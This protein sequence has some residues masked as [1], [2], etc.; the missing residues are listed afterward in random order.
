MQQ[1]GLA[2]PLPDDE[3]LLP[4][5]AQR[6]QLNFAFDTA[7]YDFRGLVLEMFQAR[8]PEGGLAIAGG[9]G[10][11]GNGAMPTPEGKPGAGRADSDAVGALL[12]NLHRTVVAERKRA[13]QATAKGGRHGGGA[14]FLAHYATVV[15]SGNSPAT[16]ALRRRFHATLL[17]FARTVVAPLLGC[18]DRPGDVAFQRSPTLRVSF[19]ATEPMGHAHT[20]AEYH[21]QAGELN[22]WL[23][24][25][26]VWGTNTL[27]VDGTGAEGG[28]NG[29]IDSRPLQLGW[30]RGVRF[31]GN[32]IRH[33]CVANES[34]FTRVSLDFRAIDVRR[35]DHTF[36]DTR[37]K[38]TPFR[39][40][41][42]YR[43]GS[44][45]DGR[46]EDVAQLKE[47]EGLEDRRAESRCRGSSSQHEK[48]ADALQDST[49][50]AGGTAAAHPVVHGGGESPVAGSSDAEGAAAATTSRAGW[51]DAA[52]A[53][54]GVGPAEKHP[55][56][57]ECGLH[58]MAG[59]SMFEM[60]AKRKAYREAQAN[61]AAKGTKRPL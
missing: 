21:H 23:P 53:L 12:S 58:K 37:G 27:W 10:S 55:P 16:E 7:A 28:D 29:D 56:F 14:A 34:G 44:D 6:E 20:D 22:F 26:A 49:A 4:T 38:P 3:A 33:H 60:A 43:L 17:A 51:A 41:Q 30:G 9:A 31:W 13:G 61:I 50:A 24:L 54:L 15:R 39:L 11:D 19:P 52:E 46:G 2:S 47:R 42:Y 18:A 8:I 5:P 40:G 1:P 45:S 48:K 32:R 25:T 35:F 57:C 36:V 59:L